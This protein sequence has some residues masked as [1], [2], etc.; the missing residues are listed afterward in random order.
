MEFVISM[1]CNQL[2]G[3]L[4]TSIFNLRVAEDA[5]TALLLFFILG[6]LLVIIYKIAK[7]GPLVN[8]MWVF[9][10]GF[11]PFLIWK[12]LGAFRRV[13][14]ETSIPLYSSLNEIGEVLESI[15]AIFILG[16]FIYMFILVKNITP[17][18]KKK[19]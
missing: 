9:I 19:A 7:E 3:F 4:C 6:I 10:V 5:I 18:I 13:F 17:K 11:M 14:I 12:S 16:A 8:R 15:S 2:S 1:D